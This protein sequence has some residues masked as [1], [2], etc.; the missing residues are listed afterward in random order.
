MYV[1]RE[2]RVNSYHRGYTKRWGKASKAFRVR[3]AL[4]GQRPGGQRP[5][6]S[7]CFDEGRETPSAQT[8][9]VVPHHGDPVLFWDVEGNWQALCDSCG[10][11]KSQAGL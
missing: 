1:P 5:V 11:R 6:M 3:Y 4:C 9:H 8:D 2:P 7:Q 10:A